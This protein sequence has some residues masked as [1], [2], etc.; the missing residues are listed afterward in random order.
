M[1]WQQTVESLMTREV[2]ST[3]ESEPLVTAMETMAEQRV[4]HVVATDDAGKLSG[5]LSN[6]D[7][8]RATLLHPERKL[9]LYGIT[10]REVMSKDPITVAANAPLADAA[11]LMLENRINAL[12][13]LDGAGS[14]AGILTT[15]DLLYALIQA[16]PPRSPQL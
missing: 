4:R 1:P 2:L 8:A 5:I 13:A 12:P 10:V 6:R 16:A 11:R 9:D 3:P 7:V 14:L 15:D